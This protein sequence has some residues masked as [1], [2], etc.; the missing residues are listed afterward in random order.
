[1]GD[2]YK[3]IEENQNMEWPLRQRFA[4]DICYGKHPPFDLHS[5]VS[6]LATVSSPDLIDLSSPTPSLA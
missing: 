2:L 4:S 5:I 3:F 6:L 1:M